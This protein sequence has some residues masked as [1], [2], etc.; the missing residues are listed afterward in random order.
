MATWKLTFPPNW[1]APADAEFPKLISWTESTE[2]GVKYFSGTATYHKQFDA[3]KEWFKPGMQGTARPGNGEGDCRSYSQR[4]ASGRNSV[5]AAVRNGRYRCTEAG[6]QRAEREG[7]Q[8][9]AQPHD[10]RFAAGRDKDLHLDGLQAIQGGFAAAGVRFAWAGYGVE[11]R[12]GRTVKYSVAENSQ[13]FPDGCAQDFSVPAAEGSLVSATKPKKR[14]IAATASVTERAVPGADGRYRFIPWMLVSIAVLFSVA[15]RIR[16]LG[17][18]LERDEGEYAYGGQLLLHGIPPYKL[19]YSMKYPGI[20]AA[21]AAIMAVFGQ[22]ITGIHLGLMLVN[23]ASIVMVYLLGKR[24]F[25]TTAGVAAAAAYALITLEEYGFGTQAHATHFVVLA[26][27]GGTL[28]LLRGMESRRWYTVLLSGVLFGIA[29]L[30]KQHGALFVV[31]GFSYLAWDGYT[32]R[33]DAWL[34]T[35][36]DLAIFVGGVSTPLVLTG[37]ALWRAGVFDKFWFWTFTYARTYVQERPLSMG[38]LAFTNNFPGIVEPN[39]AIW[40]IALL[41]L[42]LIWWRKKD[43]ISAIFLS[44]FLVFSCLAVCP[45]LY[46]REHYFLLMLPAVALLAGA[47]IGIAGNQWPRVSFLI[48]GV[49][50]VALVFSVLQQRMFLFQMSPVEIARD[51]YAANPFPEAIE[52]ANYIRKHTEKDARIAVIGSE[53]EI[54]FYAQ[55]INASGHIYMY[56]L[57]EVQPYAVTMQKEFIHEVE[58]AQPEYVVFVTST[59][60]WLRMKKSPTE[61]FEMVDRLP[62]EIL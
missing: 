40:L 15:V 13:S 10:R 45:G 53:P 9:V 14:R 47:A 57:M 23:I 17:I 20:Y 39:I 32:R 36:K 22:T 21:Y 60:S 11:Q 37:V 29:V 38:V 55:R 41:G 7:D 44:V 25:S 3:P 58:M 30:M 49:F 54:P 42:L 61:I 33:R 50:G 52:I 6:R 34:S 62:A 46:F 5:E 1:G 28:L 27:L 16:L 48:Y 31:F 4:Q 8:P 43:R 56:G 24:L 12:G 51:R 2:T 26:A 19:V 35:V 18:P 59:S